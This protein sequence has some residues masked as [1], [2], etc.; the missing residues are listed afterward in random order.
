MKM[1]DQY[2]DVEGNLTLE[3]VAIYAEAIK[4]EKVA[5]LP[6]GFQDY[7]L[8]VPNAAQEVLE[9]YELI[10]DEELDSTYYPFDKVELSAYTVPQTNE[11]LDA[12]L[13]EILQEALK[14]E[15][16]PNKRLER[17]M[18]QTVKGEST[19]KVLTPKPNK[20]CID[21]LNFTFNTSIGQETYLTIFNQKDEEVIEYEMEEGIINF[22][23]M[24]GENNYPS[25]LY[26][27]M[28]DN[29]GDTQTRRF[30]VCQPNDA[31]RILQAMG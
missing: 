13:A 10:A 22:E 2:F 20:L 19:L 11:D 15:V 23:V 14:E 1:I 4:L 30:Y 25:G 24:L 3:G 6:D 12:F 26:Y 28:L 31:K 27:W 16:V 21:K 29:D 8:N 9:I 18:L 5:E 17:R 7:I